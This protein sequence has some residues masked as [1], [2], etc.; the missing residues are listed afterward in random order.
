M[1]IQG[2]QCPVAE[3]GPERKTEKT[4]VL[5]IPPFLSLAEARQP[6]SLDDDEQ[7]DWNYNL[8]GTMAYSAAMAYLGAENGVLDKVLLRLT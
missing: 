5:S 2:L 6:K 8:R 1:L 7:G 4:W 3:V